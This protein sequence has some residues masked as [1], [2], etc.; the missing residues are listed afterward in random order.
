M[1][2]TRNDCTLLFY[3]KNQGVSYK[4]TLMLGRL[5]LFATKKDIQSCIDKYRNNTLQ[6]ADVDFPDEYAEP[7]FKILGAETVDSMDVSDFEK[8]TILHDMNKPIG[9]ELKNRFTSVI[10]GGTLEHVFNFPVA[11]KNCMEMLQVGGHYI[12]FAPTNNEMGHGFYQ[13]SPELWYR[14]FSEENGFVVKKMFITLSQ[15]DGSYGWYEVADPQQVNSRVT[16]VNDHPLFILFIAEKIKETPIFEKTP[17]QIDYVGQWDT[18][19]TLSDKLKPKSAAK[20]F[21]KNLPEGI[22][23][24]FRNI[25]DLYRY[26]NHNRDGLGKIN[27]KHFRKVEI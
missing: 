27:P 20:S 4:K 25:Y 1:G 10:D 5:N 22:Q 18:G 23:R 19:V 2:V 8:A 9:P 6:L 21:Y 16:L 12:G 24:V 7:L 26:E 14:V 3:G 17:Q 11:I 15:N 13:F